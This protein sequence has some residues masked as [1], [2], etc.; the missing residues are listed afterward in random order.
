MDSKKI[1][2]LPLHPVCRRIKLH[3]RKDIRPLNRGKYFE[4]KP[5]IVDQIV[6]M[7]NNRQFPTGL[8]RIVN[9]RQIG[10]EPELQLRIVDTGTA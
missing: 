5:D 8:I 1:E 7:I 4:S 3:S 2:S 9:R 6:K 10:E